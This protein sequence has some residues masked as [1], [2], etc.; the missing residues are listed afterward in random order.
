MF[1]QGKY[2]AAKGIIGNAI[3][4]GAAEDESSGRTLS[5]ISQGT[6]VITDEMA[7]L[8]K[9]GKTTEETLANL[10]RDTEN[11]HVAAQRLDVMDLQRQAE[12]EQIIKKAV[13]AEA[14]KFSDE[15]YRTMFLKERAIYEVIRGEDGKIVFDENGVPQTRKLTQ[16]EKENLKPGSGGRVKVFTNGIFGDEETALGYTAQNIHGGKE[17]IYLVTF[18]QA[19]S[20]IAEFMVVGCQKFLENDFWGLANATAEIRD[21]MESYGNSGLDLSGNNHGSM[22]IG[23]A[24]ESLLRARNSQESLGD[25][26][27]RFFGP[28]YSA[29]RAAGMLYELSG[30]RQNAVCLQSHKGDI[31]GV[32]GGNRVTYSAVP[33]NS[34]KVKEWINVFKDSPSVRSCYGNALQE[35]VDTYGKAKIMEIKW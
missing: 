12:A 10:N 13:F 4:N 21:L 8:E 22:T 33:D 18:P 9:T 14:I 17:A 35:C 19:D 27:I 6:I 15:A 31:V 3:D 26:L 30:G 32:L 5:A 11:A 16:S 7:Q 1:T 34:Y 23:N 2:G 29:E 28:A 24:M 25:T 20:F